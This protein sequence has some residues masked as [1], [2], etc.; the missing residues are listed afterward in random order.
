M[1]NRGSFS[2][3]SVCTHFY[4]VL[5]SLLEGRK[6]ENKRDSKLSSKRT[7]SLGFTLC[8]GVLACQS[9]Q[10]VANACGSLYNIKRDGSF[11]GGKG[12]LV[13]EFK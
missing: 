2:T 11:H 1:Y 12:G 9:W 4:P 7:A 13:S 3:T 6:R 8:A 10:V 5:S